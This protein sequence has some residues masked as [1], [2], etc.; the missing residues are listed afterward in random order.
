M[1]PPA[2]GDATKKYVQDCEGEFPIT[3]VSG[4][5]KVGAQLKQ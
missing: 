4:G 2:W 1:V 3:V 5:K